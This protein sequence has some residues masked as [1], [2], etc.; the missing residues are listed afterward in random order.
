MD[1]TLAREVEA[2]D[3]ADLLA[4]VQGLVGRVQEPRPGLAT[5]EVKRREETL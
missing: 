4:S 1:P 3:I 2:E 5:A